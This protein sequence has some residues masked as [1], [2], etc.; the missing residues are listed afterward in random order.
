MTLPTTANWTAR[1]NTIV[2]LFNDE[3]FLMAEK[4]ARMLLKYPRLSQYFRLRSL[5]LLPHSVE[6]WYDKILR[7]RAASYS[8]LLRSMK[9]TAYHLTSGR[10]PSS[11][12]IRRSPATM[13]L[14]LPPKR[15]SRM[16]RISLFISVISTS[17]S[18]PTSRELEQIESRARQRLSS[19]TSQAP[20]PSTLMVT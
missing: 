18:P 12:L 7:T 13:I 10:K 14:S 6:S 11:R 9:E 16:S 3:R 5:I 17:S 20:I 15:T 4:E 2:V 8:L 19:P 1:I